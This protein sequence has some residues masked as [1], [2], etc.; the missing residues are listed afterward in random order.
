MGD[1]NTALTT[2]SER[3][4]RNQGADQ[5]LDRIGFPYDED[6]SSADQFSRTTLIILRETFPFNGMGRR[7]QY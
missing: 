5:I 2:T 6:G 7:A 4:S 1:E 3:N